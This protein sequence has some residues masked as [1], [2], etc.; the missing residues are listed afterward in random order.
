MPHSPVAELTDIHKS[1]GKTQAVRGVDLSV[2]A[3]EVVAMLGPN[4]AGKTTTLSI[5]LGLRQ[6]DRGRAQLFGGDP[7]SPQTRQNIGVTPQEIALPENL[8]VHEV[9]SFV[10]AHYKRPIEPKKILEKFDLADIA[11][12]QVGGL[13]G[14]QKRRLSVA[15][16]FAPNAPAVFLDEPTTGLDVQIRRQVWENARDYANDGGT[17]FFTTH[18]LDEA[19]ALATRVILIDRGRIVRAGSVQEIKADVGLRIVR[20][21]SSQMID[22]P[23]TVRHEADGERHTHYCHDADAATRDLVN[24]GAPFHNL[25]VLPVSLEEAVMIALGEGE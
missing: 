4:G 16:A 12:R 13:S 6:P 3:G 10:G 2:Q 23:G 9:V 14:G 5:L 1:F 18:Y 21:T 8:Y 7:R 20:Y 11:R 19:E 17:I 25:E 22:L 15:L 24:S